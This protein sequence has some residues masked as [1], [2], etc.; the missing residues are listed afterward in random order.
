VRAA[1]M[2][3]ERI[4]R[5]AGAKPKEKP[6]GEHG[7]P[8]GGSDDF[9]EQ[10]KRAA[11][12]NI[13]AWVLDLF[14][15][16]KFQPG[17]GAWRVSSRDLGRNR[18]EDLSIHPAGS[19]T[20]AMKRP[21]LDRPVSSAAVP[22]PRRLHCGYATGSALIRKP[23]LHRPDQDPPAPDDAIPDISVL[24][25]NRRP[26]RLSRGCAW[27]RMVDTKPRSGFLSR[28]QS[29]LPCSHWRPR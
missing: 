12:A 8:R 3:A 22:R 16:A 10:V 28:R 26:H 14:P 7:S 21:Q 5:E 6:K 11:L 1:V 29:R 20:S 19:R 27:Q 15:G 17:T 18:E 25:L 4:L 23:W 13:A 24:R 2:E 9:F